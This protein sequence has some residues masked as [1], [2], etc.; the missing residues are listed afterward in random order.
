MKKL[1]GFL[2]CFPISLLGFIV[3]GLFYV[4]RQ[5]QQVHWLSDPALVWVVRDKSCLD[6]LMKTWFGFSMGCHIV[7]IKMDLESCNMI[8]ERTH[9][10]QNYIF[11]VFFF[12]LYI[13]DSIY[14]YLTDFSKHPY[15]DNY[16]ERWA[17]MEAGQPVDVPRDDW[18]DGRNDRNPWW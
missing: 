2:W 17:R 9:V 11:G 13:L 16:F 8:H 10:K 3:F 14:I 5:F 18:P 7:C 1:L 6:R 12:L 15:I 4:F